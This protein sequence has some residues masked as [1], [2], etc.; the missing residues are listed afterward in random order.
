MPKVEN[1]LADGLG[2]VGTLA[3]D[4]DERDAVHEEDDVQDGVLARAVP[5]PELVDHSEVVET[6]SVG[7]PLDVLHRGRRPAVPGGG[8]AQHEST[9]QQPGGRQVGLDDP[10]AE[11]HAGE[12]RDGAVDVARAHPG[13]AV[14]GPGVDAAQGRVEQVREQ[15]RV[16]VERADLPA[17]TVRPPHRL[18]L[19]DHRPLH[20]VPLH[21]HHHELAPLPVRPLEIHSARRDGGARGVRERERRT[22]V[23]TYRNA[24]VYIRAEACSGQR[25]VAPSR[26]SPAF[27]SS[28]SGAGR[29]APL[30][31]AIR[32]MP[33]QGLGHPVAQEAELYG[34]GA[35]VGQ[36]VGGVGEQVGGHLEL[37]ALDGV[38][39]AGDVSG[40]VVQDV[41][42]P[43]LRR[44]PG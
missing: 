35:V 4:G 24:V 43:A 37:K 20:L 9:E 22:G 21:L 44:G 31:W 14:Q 3:L 27:L 6:E 1:S 13:H 7:V 19:R 25:S 36:Q 33:P 12:C 38:G 40:A 10:L 16:D 15:G 2:K 18:E 28:R 17:R 34:G 30:L 8:L 41:A 5:D 32:T 29:R 39:D 11:R 42:G 23:R 26:G